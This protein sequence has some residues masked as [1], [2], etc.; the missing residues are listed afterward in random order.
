MA[1]KWDY[2]QVRHDCVIKC[3]DPEATEN[4]QACAVLHCVLYLRS[5]SVLQNF[6]YSEEISD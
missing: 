5:V 4:H 6:I 1:K 2:F 3:V